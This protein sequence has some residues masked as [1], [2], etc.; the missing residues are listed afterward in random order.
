MNDQPP[1]GSATPQAE[2]TR[3]RQTHKSD[4]TTKAEQ[5]SLLNE[6]NKRMRIPQNGRIEK[7]G[8]LCWNKNEQMVLLHR[9][10][11]PPMKAPSSSKVTV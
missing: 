10:E 4:Q 1:K 7:K 11:H 8:H 5:S 6:R 2:L 3:A 9:K